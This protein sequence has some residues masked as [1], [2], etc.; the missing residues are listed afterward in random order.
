[1][2][3]NLVPGDYFAVE[4]GPVAP[5]RGQ[6]VVYRRRDDPNTL[7]IHRVVALAGDTIELTGGQLKVNDTVVQ[8]RRLCPLVEASDDVESGEIVAEGNS[9]NARI[10]LSLASVGAGPDLSPMVVPDGEV[11]VLGD[12]RA[13]AADSRRIGTVSVADIFGVPLYVF[14]S[15]DVSRF[16]ADL[17]TVT[18]SDEA[19]VCAAKLYLFD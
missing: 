1:M 17:T 14:W 6:V 9:G 19:R 13:N 5:S 8:Q 3:P 2:L 10:I 7:Y 4:V 11:I 15:S 12:F 18:K 16:A